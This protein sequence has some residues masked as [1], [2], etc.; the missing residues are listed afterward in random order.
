VKQTV[1]QER[2][3]EEKTAAT[4]RKRDAQAAANTK[5]WLKILPNFEAQ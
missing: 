2:A 4:R 5:E 3:A 1:E